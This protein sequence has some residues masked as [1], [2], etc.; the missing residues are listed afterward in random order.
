[1]NVPALL[2]PEH[3]PALL[4]SGVATRPTARTSATFGHRRATAREYLMCPP[5][6]FDVTYAINEW[7]SMDVPVDRELAGQQWRLL[8]DIY[9]DLG[10]TVHTIEPVPGL[11]DMVFAANSCIMVDGQ[12]L[13]ARFRHPERAAEA[14]AYRAWFEANEVGVFHEPVVQNEGEGDFA[15]VGEMILAGTGFRTDYAAH[16][17]AQETFGHPVISLKLRNPAYYHLDVALFALD[18]HNIAYYPDAFSDGSRSALERLFPDA[19]I[20]TRADAEAFGLNS[21]S[22]GYNV[23]VAREAVALIEQL[24][25]RGYRPV[26]VDLSE[27][28]KAGGGAKC[29]TQEI[30]RG[31]APEPGMRTRLSESGVVAVL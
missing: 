1:M 7:M 4:D 11:P 15:A 25:D 28:R 14:P 12:V 18:D 24:A 8:V 9:R 31:T 13:G 5:R 21:V 10:H 30:R 16:A 22:D 2:V 20:A 3:S 17:E 6:Y 19:V 27:F 23:V 26:P 29:C